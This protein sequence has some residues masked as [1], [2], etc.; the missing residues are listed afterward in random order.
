MKATGRKGAML[1]IPMT[2]MFCVTM[3]ALGMSIWGIFGHIAAGT[4]VFMVHGLQL[5]LAVAL[6]ALALLVVMHSVPK[7]TA[8]D[9]A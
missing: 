4:F 5:I 3:T 9:K 8:A 1:Y 2:I 7:L 6:I